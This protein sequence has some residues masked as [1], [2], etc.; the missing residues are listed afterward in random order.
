MY[1]NTLLNAGLD[2]IREF[3][4]SFGIWD[5]IYEYGGFKMAAI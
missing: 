5:Q 1:I 2:D 4:I 3:F